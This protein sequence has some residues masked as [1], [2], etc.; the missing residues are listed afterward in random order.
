MIHVCRSSSESNSNSTVIAAAHARRRRR[1]RTNAHARAARAR[2]HGIDDAAAPPLRMMRARSTMLKMRLLC[3]AAATIVRVA[4][5][6][7]SG[8]TT[9]LRNGS[10]VV[11]FDSHTIGPTNVT[12]ATR[13]VLKGSSASSSALT[14]RWS[15][16][17]ALFGGA[18]PSVSSQANESDA[19]AE[20]L[21]AKATGDGGW[22]E[23]LRYHAVG[24]TIAREWRL[25]AARIELT[26]DVRVISTSRATPAGNPTLLEAWVGA[27][28]YDTPDTSNMTAR[29]FA[30]SPQAQFGIECCPGCMI[31]GGHHV[32]G[33]TTG[34]SSAIYA[35]LHTAA[36]GVYDQ[37]AGWGAA[38]WLSSVGGMPERWVIASE[39]SF[40]VNAESKRY[41]PTV[42]AGQWEH[43]V[44]RG[45][46]SDVS[47][48]TGGFE[49]RLTFFDGEPLSFL[50]MAARL[51][52]RQTLMMSRPHPDPASP[53][54]GGNA[55]VM[56][57]YYA[58]GAT[59]TSQDASESLLQQLQ[60]VASASAA[61]ILC[62]LV[63]FTDGFQAGDFQIAN[64]SY[65][66]AVRRLTKLAAER[67]KDVLI[68]SYNI[69]M[70]GTTSSVW[71]KYHLCVITVRTGILD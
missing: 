8:T 11:T 54:P 45:F 28:L 20:L 70:V 43:F 3:I 69:L 41:N 49:F 34:L 62:V 17:G 52:I 32:A 12:H 24:I 7:S 1:R 9:T 64:N 66:A 71:R 50:D 68:A 35:P 56:F 48:M 67:Y 19:T 38:T 61:K 47:A 40:D 57:P 59:G 27:H 31:E 26:C 16:R 15:T 22:L 58:P 60:R 37:L 39:G 65:V 6:P 42:C 2:M 36:A 18:K 33:Q 4:T 21:S 5:S 46:T 23:T 44:F 14:M 29:Y 30:P 51:P 10:I 53:L 13:T 55:I 63:V 25:D